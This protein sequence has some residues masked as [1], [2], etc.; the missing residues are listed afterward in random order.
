MYMLHICGIS[1][2]KYKE[3]NKN[4]CIVSLAQCP[5]YNFKESGPGLYQIPPNPVMD[6]SLAQKNS[7]ACISLLW[8]SPWRNNKVRIHL[9]ITKIITLERTDNIFSMF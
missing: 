1:L 3:V 2:V 4:L 7:P 8:C 9:E 5:F 6:C